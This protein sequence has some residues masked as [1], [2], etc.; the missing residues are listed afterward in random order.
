MSR[1]VPDEV[2][3]ALTT[4]VQGVGFHDKERDL[5]VAFDPKQSRAEQVALFEV[6][7]D[8]LRGAA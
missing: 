3:D 2:A 4:W 7:R 8:W 5:F 6:A 1:E